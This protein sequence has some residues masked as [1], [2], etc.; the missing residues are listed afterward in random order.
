[1]T[2]CVGA[3]MER[4]KCEVRIWI[5]AESCYISVRAILFNAVAQTQVSDKAFA[6]VVIGGGRCLI[7]VLS[8]TLPNCG[9]KQTLFTTRLISHLDLEMICVTGRKC[10]CYTNQTVGP[11]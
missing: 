4:G 10:L 5:Y 3:Y 7:L 9:L 11:Y 6:G 8:F 1:M 2:F